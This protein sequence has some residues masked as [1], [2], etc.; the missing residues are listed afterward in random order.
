MAGKNYVSL[1][2]RLGADPD[3]KILGNQSKVVK[4]PI[5][6]S[7]TYANRHGER[8]EHTEWHNIVLWRGLADVAE[9][10]VKKGD[11]VAIDGKLRTRKYEKDGQT[12]YRTEI[13]ATDLILL[14][15]KPVEQSNDS[16]SA[17]SSQPNILPDTQHQDTLKETGFEGDLPF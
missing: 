14:S 5:A 9:R 10:F 6:T 2:G 3:V 1:I 16:A 11:M 17:N 15:K 12:H 4:F 13:E 7:E 8:T